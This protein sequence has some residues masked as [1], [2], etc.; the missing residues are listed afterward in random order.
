MQVAKEKEHAK[1]FKK[2][3]QEKKIPQTT[4]VEL[5]GMH[6]SKINR[7]VNGVIDLSAGE[8]FQLLDLM[9][10]HFQQAYWKRKLG[11]ITPEKVV[12]EK[13]SL[14]EAVEKLSPLE[15]IRIIKTI[16]EKGNLFKQ[17]NQ[18]LANMG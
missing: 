12:S 8:F 1:I 4:L 13:E 18:Q 14:E 17:Q 2:L 6:Q 3:L 15:Q 7:F 10:P 5:S 16:S 11:I 9:P